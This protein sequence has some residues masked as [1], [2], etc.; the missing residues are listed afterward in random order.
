[1]STV[2][3]S[4]RIAED[5]DCIVFTSNLIVAK[6]SNEDNILSKILSSV[7]FEV[8]DIISILEL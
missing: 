4:D 3:I 5:I 7:S 1:M 6:Y 2:T 8:V